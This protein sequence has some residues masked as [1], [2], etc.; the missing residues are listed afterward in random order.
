MLFVFGGRPIQLLLPPACPSNTAT[1]RLVSFPSGMN[2]AEA[3]RRSVE[4][5]VPLD[6]GE[7]NVS[8]IMT[9]QEC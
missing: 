3:E 4:R 5:E 9:E 7:I 8:V 1:R 6:V 2:P